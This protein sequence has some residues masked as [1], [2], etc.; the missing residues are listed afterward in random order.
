[1][2]GASKADRGSFI[3]TLLQARAIGVD[4]AE[5]V[6]TVKKGQALPA[7]SAAPPTKEGSPM[8]KKIGRWTLGV[9]SS[10]MLTVPALYARADQTQQMKDDASQAGH[11]MKNAGKS[12]G[13]AAKSTGKATGHAAEG[14]WDKSKSTAK[15]AGN[16]AEHA[17]HK[18]A[19][20]VDKASGK[21]T[22]THVDENTGK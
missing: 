7:S 11:E 9:A 21:A 10:V 18:A 5:I 12:T 22:N 16:S 3:P 14:T 15:S 1:M 13:E 20:T 17:G 19:G 6:S 2:R 4:V 8:W